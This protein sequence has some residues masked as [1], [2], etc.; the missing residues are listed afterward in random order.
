MKNLTTSL[1][2]NVIFGLNSTQLNYEEKAFFKEVNPLGF[3]LFKRNCETKEQIKNLIRSLKDLLGRDSIL[4]LIDQEGGR[5]ARL[6]PPNFR[7][8]LPAKIFGDLALMDLEQAKVAVY[9]NHLLMGRELT[10][11]GINVDCTPVADLYYKDANDI[12]GDRSYGNDPYIVGE[13]CK[14]ADI[15]L[16]DAGVQSIIKHI[17][18]HGRADKDSHLDL[19]I[20]NENLATLEQNDFKV[21]SR[22][23]DLNLAMTAHIIYSAIDDKFPATISPRVIDYIRNIIGFKGLL[24]TD[25][26]SMKALTGSLKQNAARALEAKCD[27]L[28]HC[29]G[30][31]EEMKEIAEAVQPL[32]TQ[33]ITKVSRLNNFL[34]FEPYNDLLY[35]TE[36]AELEERLSAIIKV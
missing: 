16:R 7:E 27:I 30:E 14:I 24:V 1:V 17:P 35:E 21:F 34:N 32:T 18:G 10:N 5:V 31:I 12:I 29:N 13:L 33:Q 11:L 20:V 36:F 3:I 15:G 9:V 22:L 8:S 28:L 2:T 26:L 19:P 23:S 4:V 6:R 25:D